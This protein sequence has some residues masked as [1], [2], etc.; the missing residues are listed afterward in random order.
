VTD[1]EDA[2]LL[3]SDKEPPEAIAS[4]QEG[5]A[6][7]GPG[8]EGVAEVGSAAE[9]VSPPVQQQGVPMKEQAAEPVRPEQGM[10][11][12]KSLGVQAGR[13]AGKEDTKTSE[14]VKEGLQERLARLHQRRMTEEPVSAKAGCPDELEIHGCRIK[15]D[16]PE[17]LL[18]QSRSSTVE[19]RF[20]MAG[21]LAAEALKKNSHL[22]TSYTVDP[23]PIWQE[24]RDYVLNR[25]NQ[26]M[27]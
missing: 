20:K 6:A 24:I 10:G 2:K 13:A 5:Y 11:E 19:Y 22:I 4:L 21:M 3:E 15:I 7:K 25:F 16:F 23:V 8:E 18:K 27:I 17:D 1:R 9:K 26:T 12:G 14:T